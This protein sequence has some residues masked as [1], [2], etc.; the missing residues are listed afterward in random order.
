MRNILIKVFLVCVMASLLLV[1]I[2]I[3]ERNIW[4]I[5]GYIIFLILFYLW[6]WHKLKKSSTDR[7]LWD[8]N[9]SD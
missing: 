7:E 3:N 2:C 1:A 6:T 5:I 4:I 8:N 9:L